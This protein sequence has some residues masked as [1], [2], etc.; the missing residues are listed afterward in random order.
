MTE[1]IISTV[2]DTVAASEVF[3]VEQ[4]QTLF[5]TALEIRTL[6]Y[7]ILGIALVF[8]IGLIFKYGYKF[9]SMFF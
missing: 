6:L 5:N 3:T 2:S 4:W 1:E 9:F 7:Y 8:F